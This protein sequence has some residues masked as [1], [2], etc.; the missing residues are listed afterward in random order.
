WPQA[1]LGLCFSWG[2]LVAGACADFAI[3]FETGLL[4]AGCVLWVIAYDTIYAVQDREDDALIGVRSTAL[5]FG[6]R[7]KWWVAGFYV[8]AA[9]LWGLAV[10]AAGAGVAPILTLS[11]IAGLLIGP[12][13]DSVKPDD[14][15]S[16]LKA[17]HF[18]AIIG[19]AV[20]AAF[21]INPAWVTLG[22]YIKQIFGHS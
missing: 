5:L 15:A 3:S 16:A 22:P 1:W 8:G 2:A 13:I 12:T 21:A 19:L 6:E 17:F 7:W 10:I 4:F 14:P 20:A 9:F 18:N 11:L